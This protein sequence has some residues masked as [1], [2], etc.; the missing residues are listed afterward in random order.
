M[1][2]LICNMKG[3]QLV[4]F[5]ALYDQ[6]TGAI[7]SNQEAYIDRLLVKYGMTNLVMRS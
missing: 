3:S 5:D 1:G 4:S 6:V 2:A 7:G